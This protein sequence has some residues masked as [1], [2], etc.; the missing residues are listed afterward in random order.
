ML[1]TGKHIIRRFAAL[2]NTPRG[3][4]WRNAGAG[5]PYGGGVGKEKGRVKTLPYKRKALR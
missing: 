2:C 4:A 3:G 1:A 5:V